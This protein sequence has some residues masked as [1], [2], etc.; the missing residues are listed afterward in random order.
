MAKCKN[1]GMVFTVYASV[2]NGRVHVCFSSPATRLAL[3]I[4]LRFRGLW[5]MFAVDRLWCWVDHR[6]SAPREGAN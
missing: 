1:L 5:I 6:D 3:T 2:V 4:D